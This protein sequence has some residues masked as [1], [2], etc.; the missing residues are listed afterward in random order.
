MKKN[1]II[2]VLIGPPAIGKSTLIKKITNPSNTFVIS[3]DDIV[4]NVANSIALTYSDM[5]VQPPND[6][7]IG[8]IDEKYGEIIQNP[9]NIN[10]PKIVFSK[11]HKAND[12]VQTIFKK[13]M[14]SAKLSDKNIVIDLTNMRVSDRIDKLNIISNPEDIR[15][16]V[17]F[18]FKGKE[19]IIKAVAAKRAE[20]AERMGKSKKIPDIVIDKM[21]SK[22]EP[23]SPEEK[24]DKIIYSNTIPELKKFAEIKEVRKLIRN[25]INESFSDGS[26]EEYVKRLKF[27]GI[28][29]FE[30]LVGRTVYYVKPVYGEHKVLKWFPSSKSYLLFTDGNRVV[31]SPFHITPIPGKTEK[32]T[33]SE[34]KW[35]IKKLC[36]NEV[37][38]IEIKSYSVNENAELIVTFNLTIEDFSQVL[39]IK[40]KEKLTILYSGV[41]LKLWIDKKRELRMELLKGGKET[42]LSGDI[43]TK[44]SNNSIFSTPN[45]KTTNVDWNYMKNAIER[46]ILEKI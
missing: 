10:Y 45:Y 36:E 21:I 33:D 19:K 8:D 5:F 25:L 42:V 13:T 28:E 14:K 27:L 34:L 37:K 11:I 24:Y 23:P 43:R 2:Y 18:N 29:K 35:V 12:I 15:I 20:T 17:V 16:A 3:R 41:V 4:E 46:I 7:K 1:R 40:E 39:N 22:Y 30:D 6:A 32:E 38:N 31:A 44:W 9:K 26:E